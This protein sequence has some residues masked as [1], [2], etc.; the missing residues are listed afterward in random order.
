M[1]PRR[2]RRS[3]PGPPKM[4][5]AEAEF[6]Q[7]LQRAGRLDALLE[8]ERARIA[9]LLETPWVEEG[10][11]RKFYYLATAKD[12]T[13]DVSRE[14]HPHV[15]ITFVPEDGRS[16]R[17]AHGIPLVDSAGCRIDDPLSDLQ[18]VL[19]TLK[20][21]RSRQLSAPDADGVTWI[22]LE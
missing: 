20:H 19:D 10:T 17:I 16:R 8:A 6:V 2:L 4:S 12:V 22:S 3:R 5:A 18:E 14:P 11:G 7:Q 9:R 15:R 13:I 1:T 21:R